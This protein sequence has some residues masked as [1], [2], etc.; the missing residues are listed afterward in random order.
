[1]SMNTNTNTPMNVYHTQCANCNTLSVSTRRDGASYAGDAPKT[2]PVCLSKDIVVRDPHATCGFC[3]AV[4]L[5]ETNDIHGWA[6][7][8]VCET[9]RDREFTTCPECDAV[10]A[11]VTITEQGVCDACRMYEETVDAALEAE[12]NGDYAD[13]AW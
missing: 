12:R 7:D 9:C 3:D 11:W 13:S 5:P 1:M 8:P 6:F 2:C 4:P 10:A